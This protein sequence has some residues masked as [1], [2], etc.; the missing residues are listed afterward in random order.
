MTDILHKLIERIK[1]AENVFSSYPY[2]NTGVS[3]IEL[4]DGYYLQSSPTVYRLF[5]DDAEIAWFNTSEH[6]SLR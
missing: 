5:K 4:Q 1:R 6:T 2:A 3:R